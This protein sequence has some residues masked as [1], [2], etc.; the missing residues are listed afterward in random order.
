MF[1]SNGICEYVATETIYLMVRYTTGK[2]LSPEGIRY[3][4]KPMDRPDFVCFVKPSLS[5]GF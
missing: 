5:I 3:G 4:L 1:Q 2:E